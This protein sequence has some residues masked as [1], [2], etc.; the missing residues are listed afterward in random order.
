MIGL[1]C[2]AMLCACAA[3]VESGDGQGGMDTFLHPPTKAPTPTLVPPGEI[4]LAGKLDAQGVTAA[5]LTLAAP[6]GCM[7]LEVDA[8]TSLVTK[9]GKPPARL[10]IAQDY[11]GKLPMKAYGVPISYAYRFGPQEVRFSKPAKIVFT[12]LKNMKKTLIF[13]ISLGIKGDSDEW[14]QISVQGDDRSV[15]T[16]LDTLLLGMRYLLVGPAPMGS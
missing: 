13:E 7:R 1:L 3:K 16:R 6:D 15:W 8:G 12:C 4:D 14:D 2:L 9:D 5:P 11:S 10:S